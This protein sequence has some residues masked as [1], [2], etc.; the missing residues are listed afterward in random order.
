MKRTVVITGAGGFVGKH[1]CKYLA[2]LGQDLRV[3]AADLQTAENLECDKF[4]KTDM[5]V[6]SE[7]DILVNENKPDFVIHLA[8][9]FGT[10]N[11]NRI[12]NANVMSL[13]NLAMALKDKETVVVTAGSAAEY[14]IPPANMLPVKEECPCRPVTFYGISKKMATDLAR[15]YHRTSSLSVTIVRPFQMLGNAA[16]DRL[17]PGAFVRRIKQAMADGTDTIKVGNLESV[18]DFLD[19][20]DAVRALWMLCEKPAP[21][22][23]F[24]ICSGEPVQ[25]SELLNKMMDVAGRK[26]N[27]EK[28]PQK[29]KG[30][31]D[32]SKMY[33][34]YSK[35]N[36]HCGW[37]PQIPLNRSIYEMFQDKS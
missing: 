8:G 26:F 19:V 32:V 9:L 13:N 30:K 15:Y 5:T 37:K 11:I 28:D 12:L 35:I 2:S 7:V 3:V 27:I 6:A 36:N 29:L 34:D 33:G 25:I 4:V 16:S 18:R 10:D 1:I 22:Q 17:A 14:G 21:A 23:I 20:R 24:N 31:K